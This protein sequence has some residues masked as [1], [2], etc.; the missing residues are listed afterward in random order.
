M[1][2]TKIARIDRPFI[3]GLKDEPVRPQD[4][5]VLEDALMP[6]GVA[7]Q[8]G[9]FTTTGQSVTSSSCL[10]VWEDVI[11]AGVALGSEPISDILFAG[12][13]T[14]TVATNS[15]RKQNISIS[16]E[17]DCDAND[18]GF[19]IMRGTFNGEVLIFSKD[20][21]TPVQTWAG[22]ITRTASTLTLSVLK[23]STIVT[24][25][26][27][28]FLS[29]DVGAYIYIG[30]AHGCRRIVQ[31]IDTTHVVVDAPWNF[32]TGAVTGRIMN[33]G[34]LNLFAKVASSGKASKNGTIVTVTGSNTTWTDFP[35]G[36][37]AVHAPSASTKE[38]ADYIEPIGID[39]GTP[40]P[41]V[42]V[43]ATSITVNGTTPP[44]WSGATAIDYVV[45]RHIPARMGAVH[46]SRIYLAGYRPFPGRLY[47]SPPRWDGRTPKN[48]E[49]SYEVEIGKAMMMAYVDVPDPFTTHEITGLLSLP[50][51]NL[52]VLCSD[53]TFVAYGEYPGI[54]VVKTSDFGNL[55]PE[56]C[57]VAENG[58]WMAGTE[59]VFEF[60]GQN[61]PSLISGD[62]DKTWRDAA[63]GISSIALGYFNGM[64]LC[65]IGASNDSPTYVWDIRNRVWSGPWS[66]GAV[67]AYCYGNRRTATGHAFGVDPYGNA[68]RLL[69][70]RGGTQAYDVS[71]TVVDHT[72]DITVTTNPGTFRARTPKDFC[73]PLTQ[74]REVKYVKVA[75]QLTGSAGPLAS[76]T[77]GPD[78]TNAAGNLSPT[79]GAE[80][81]EGF[82][83]PDT[84]F[85][86]TESTLGTRTNRFDVE[87][88]RTAGTITKFAVHEIEAE[89]KE[90]RHRG[91]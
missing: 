57:L 50:S 43:S 44:D 15:S 3:G 10:D 58:A 82:F 67:Y 52:G 2:V 91:V 60:R 86:G 23:G 54:S 73:G 69:A 81:G 27:A 25:S 7:C 62:I 28:S 65:T 47:I 71:T 18:Q 34:T 42:S 40:L 61:T 84:G 8:R 63:D 9:G 64:L 36:E 68:N 89:V 13:T 76:V 24:C 78:G 79:T 22:N 87:I 6:A 46:K 33:V 45:G 56:S 88:E 4:A 49:F 31:F 38:I 37:V 19:R 48:N 72:Q 29:T 5:A 12:T 80:I 14:V 51:G 21:L 41:V 26:T 66:L 83:T 74:D 39:Y 30:V 17:W 20:G 35:Q 16:T 90:Y 70:A 11:G 59:G 77:P 53:T 32:D 75:H 85:S 1:A 55:S